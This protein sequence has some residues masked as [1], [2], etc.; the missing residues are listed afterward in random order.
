MARLRRIEPCD[1][2]LLRRVRLAA[3]EDSPGAFSSTLRREAARTDAEWAERAAAGSSGASRLTVFAE[4]E[5]GV[6]GLVGG[7]RTTASSTTVELVS[8]WVA[9]GARRA[10]IGRQLVLAVVDW[11]RETG[12]SEVA[13]GVTSGNDAAER[14]YAAMGFTPT[15]AAVPLSSNPSLVELR[16]VRPIA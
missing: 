15:G 16:M 12:A 6:V 1:G 8:M 3:L 11:A 5:R 14:L 7:Y 10:G 2:P 4:G 13:L 9:P